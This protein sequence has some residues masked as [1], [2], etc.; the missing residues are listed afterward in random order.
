MKQRGFTLIELMV[1]VA[2]AAILLTLATPSMYDFIL[3]QRLK[4]IHAQINTD[5]QWARSE[6]ASLNKAVHVTFSS[7]GGANCYL[8]Y[9]GPV[10]SCDC[11]ITPA[12]RANP[13]VQELRS[14]QLPAG[15]KVLVEANANNV[16]DILTTSPAGAEVKSTVSTHELSFDPITGTK[17]LAVS[18]NFL[19]AATAFA[20]DARVDTARTLTT[21]VSPAG[22]PTSCAPTGSNMSEKPCPP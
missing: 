16:E 22:R 15:G 5:L 2:I 10:R 9:T 6:A 12:C 14:V 21:L 4:S 1:V 3:T 11:P 19:I 18:D 7:A 17:V 20:I 13:A 8:I